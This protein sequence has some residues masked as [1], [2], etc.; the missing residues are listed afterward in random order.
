M[1]FCSNIDHP[2]TISINVNIDGIPIYKSS[3]AQFWPI[4]FNIF[5]QP[6]VKPMT[7]AIFLGTSKPESLE[8]FLRPF[9]NELTDVLHHGIF[10]N[11]HKITIRLRCFICDSPAR[12]FL[13]GITHVTI[14][15]RLII[16]FN[17]FSGV[18]SFNSKNGCL[19]CT[20]EGEYSYESRT[21]IFTSL[22]CAKRTDQEFRMNSY[23]RHQK[24]ATPLIDIPDLDLIQNIIVGD[25][26]HLIDLGVM[27]RLLIGWR[28]GT[29]GFTAK[30]SA[31]QINDLSATLRN[32]QLPSEIH[33]KFRGLDHLAHWKGTEFNN[34]L[35]YASIVVLKKHL[36]ADA[37]QHFLLFYCSITMLSSDCYKPNWHVARKMLEKFIID[38]MTI[39]GQQYITSN[40]HNLQHIVDEVEV[41]GPL[42]TMAAYP[43]ENGLQR[44]KHLI[45]SGS[46]TLEQVINRLS[47]VNSHDYYNTHKSTIQYPSIKTCGD[48]VR[49]ELEEGFSLS[50]SH[51]NGWFLTKTNQVVRFVNAT[52]TTSI[53]IHGRVVIGNQNFFQDPFTSSVL[54]VFY[55][56]INNLSADE[57]FFSYSEIKCKLVAV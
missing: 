48:S 30:L 6:E 32:I 27:K 25:R 23:R 43:F 55:G 39:Y 20:C 21:V 36:S 10:M 33:R 24:T 31:H 56:S 9:V 14:C 19:K 16:F 8:E 7:I 12:A 41:F 34:F 11:G 47:E 2:I 54:H 44:I 5:E 15:A 22:N 35:H 51:R 29:L 1:Y 52:Q 46:K 13:K 18:Y 45:R 3:K 50:T 40:I 38:F 26:L 42:S 53:L 17:N 37:Y 49:A 4:L 28:D 57:L